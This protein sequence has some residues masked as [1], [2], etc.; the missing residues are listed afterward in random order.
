MIRTAAMAILLATSFA[1]HASDEAKP[2]PAKG[3]VVAETIC[4]ACHGVDG[5]SV[6]A[7]NPHLAGQVQEYI[8][9]Q[10][11]NFKTEG[12]K[13][14]LRNNAIMAGMVMAITPED[15]P[16]VA[17]WFASQKLNPTPVT[18]DAA[19]LA[20]GKKLWQQGHAK[21][22]IPACSG[23]HGPE[24][25]GMPAQYPQLAGQFPSYT[26]TQLKAFRTGERANDPEKMMQDVAAKLSDQEIAAVAQYAASLNK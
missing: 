24:G 10:L 13:P 2:D 5:N 21:K 26:E 23:C 22:G 17:A 18:A 6:D 9:K 11:N 14:A 19:V 3:K 20:L 1:A 25:N 8:I 15:I 7:A 4:V 16:N 12:D